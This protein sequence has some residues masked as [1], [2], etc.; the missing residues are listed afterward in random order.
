MCFIFVVLFVVSAKEETAC[1]DVD[2]VKLFNN[3]TCQWHQEFEL[4]VTHCPI[5]ITWF[6]FDE[7]RCPIKYESKRYE[8][9][10]LNSSVANSPKALKY[11]Q[12]S[13]EWNIV[14]RHAFSFSIFSVDF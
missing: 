4:A 8:S 2:Y 6:P 7:Q 1:C 13:S 11:Y 12:K 9:Q 14:G 10:E 3:G 5:D